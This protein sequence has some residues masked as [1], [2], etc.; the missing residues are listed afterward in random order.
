MERGQSTD[1]CAESWAIATTTTM[2]R[3][4]LHS[5][6]R[7]C[8]MFRHDPFS[9]QRMNIRRLTKFRGNAEVDR[10]WGWFNY[11]D[12]HCCRAMNSLKLIRGIWGR[13]ALR[14]DAKSD[15]FW[16]LMPHV[17]QIKI[18]RSLSATNI[19]SFNQFHQTFLRCFKRHCANCI[20]NQCFAS[21][22]RKS[23]AF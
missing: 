13:P 7:C 3:A 18:S 14:W 11:G 1:F 23:V 19:F 10:K 20:S 16:I 2:V 9:S 5:H 22:I 17:K 4:D 15:E 21:L 12:L 8:L 6:K